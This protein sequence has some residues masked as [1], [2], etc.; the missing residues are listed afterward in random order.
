MKD[1]HIFDYAK[2]RLSGYDLDVYAV[3]GVALDEDLDRLAD[4]VRL[5]PTLDFI[6]IH[7]HGD[8]SYFKHFDEVKRAIENAKVSAILNCTEFETTA[9]YRY[10]FRQEEPEYIRLLRYQEIG[11]D[12]NMYATA[13]WALNTFDGC[14]LDVPEAVQPMTEGIYRPGQGAVPIAEGVKDI[15]KIGRAH[16]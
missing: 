2:R 11:G 10:L 3:D 7:V 16:V 6:I 4:F 14:R 1:G 13:V 8:V 9:E 5:I 12:E 15:D